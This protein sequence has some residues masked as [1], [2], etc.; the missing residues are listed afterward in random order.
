MAQW[1]IFAFGGSTPPRRSDPLMYVTLEDTWR[2]AV[3]EGRSLHQDGYYV[4]A[5]QRLTRNAGRV[6]VAEARRLGYRIK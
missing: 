6:G 1:Y 4:L 2:E 5:V 3:R